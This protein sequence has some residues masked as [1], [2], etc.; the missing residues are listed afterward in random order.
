MV[1]IGTQL[2]AEE[3]ELVIDYLYQ[4]YGPG[5]GDPMRAGVLPADSPVQADGRVSSENVVLPDGEGKQLVQGLC[6]MCHD[7]GVVVAT[8]RGEDDWNRYTE[9]MLRQNGIS[10]PGDDEEIM[11]SYLN[12]HFGIADPR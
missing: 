11:V 5:T 2:D 9:N 3:M 4:T 1:V 12:Q 6:T 7:L 8:R 10:V